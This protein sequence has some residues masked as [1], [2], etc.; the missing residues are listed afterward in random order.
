MADLALLDRFDLATR[1]ALHDTVRGTIRR[2]AR[3]LDDPQVVDAVLALLDSV[4]A[5]VEPAERAQPITSR[6]RWWRR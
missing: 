5:A 3:H 2:A 1:F 6:R 4:R